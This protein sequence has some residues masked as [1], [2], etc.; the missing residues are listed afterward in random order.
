MTSRTR[1]KTREQTREKIIEI[2]RD[3]G[4]GRRILPPPAALTNGGIETG[5]QDEKFYHHCPH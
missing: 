5:S 4:M 1:K 3:M 2:L